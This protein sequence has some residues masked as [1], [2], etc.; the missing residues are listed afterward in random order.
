MTRGG[1]SRKEA[2]QPTTILSTREIINF[3]TGNVRTMYEVG[4]TAQVVAEMTAYRLDILG[5]SES[6][7]TG[8]GQKILTTGERIL[9]SGHEEEDAPHTEGVALMLSKKAQ[10]ALI[11]WEGHG[12]RIMT[13]SFRTKQK[14]IKMNILQCYAPTNES[15]DEAKDQFY[16]R[17][18]T[19]IETLSDRDINIAMGDFNA[20]VGS[21]NRGF[22]E[23]MGQQGLGQMNDNGER[24]ADICASSNLVI[25]G[26][27]FSHKR[28]HKATWVSPD[29]ATE[30][31]IDHICISKKFRRSLMDV[32]VKRGADVASDHHLVVGRLKLK[33]KRNWTGET[34]QRQKF[35]TRMLKDAEKLEEYKLTLSNR[36]QVLEEVLEEETIDE[37]WGK[38]KDTITSTC[39]EI[40][41]HYKHTH[42]EWITPETLE[43]VADRKR[44]KAVLNNSRTRAEKAR[45]QEAYST[46]NRSVKNSIKAD[47]RNFIE[48]LAAE[49]EEAARQGNMRDLYNTTKKLSG[50]FSKPE[51]PVKDKQGRAI[52]GEEGQKNRWREH[53]EELLNR[54]APQDPPD[55]QPA[56]NDLLINC[57]EPTEEEIQG[58]IKQLKSGKAAGPDGIPAEALKADTETMVKMLH[59]LFKEIWKEEQVPTEWK[60]GYL[61]KLPKKG[62]LSNCA[63]YRGITLLSVP[64]KVF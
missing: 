21:D 16:T 11:G 52:Q 37:R 15:D 9:F 4:K 61:I 49:A 30:N 7:W 34:C 12:P 43:K 55:I 59:P 1:E 58:A 64:G 24:F 27:V 41:G 2:I 54:P 39:K 14:R 28:I 5:I 18:Q 47:K 35:N 26:T 22:E 38:V 10:R 23:V 57:G 36:F 53:F 48:A 40:L 42:K 25:G 29:H 50:K 60:E 44:R 31:Q 62:D 32:K 20:K 13:A 6:R 8:S 63:N 17:L 19:I 33:L 56:E 46:A 3:G 45:N 51:R